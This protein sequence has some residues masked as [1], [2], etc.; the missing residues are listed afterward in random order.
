M[1]IP[2]WDLIK[3]QDHS[4]PTAQL[5]EE[6]YKKHGRPLRIA[7]DE[8]DWRFNN[9]TSQQVFIIRQ[10]SNQPAFQGVEKAMLY[11][12]C[13]MLTLNIQ[14]L[15]VFDG[16]RRPWKRGKR[17]GNKIDYESLRLLKELL[18]HFRIPHH[19]AP[20]EA[21]AECARLQ[22]LGI[23]D[24]VWSQDSDSLLFGCDLL[25]RDDRIARVK[26]N[27]DRSK[28]NTKKDGKSIKVVKGHEI[29]EKHRFDR[30]GLVLFAIIPSPLSCDLGL[31]KAPMAGGRQKLAKDSPPAS[32]A[33]YTFISGGSSEV[34]HIRAAR[35]QHFKD[36]Q[37]EGT[38]ASAPPASVSVTAQTPHRTKPMPDI[39][40]SPNTVIP[41]LQD[42]NAIECIDFT[43]L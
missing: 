43:D 9:L 6:H 15:F 4:V 20:G 5:A 37:K 25:I 11:R 32:P 13:H 18:A 16:P 12:I 1:G 40:I 29:V 2:I 39:V 3:E 38:C 42:T 7:V 14:L 30:E 10:K 8:A 35:L 17:G 19:E 22:V 26:G 33:Q 31:S 21:E 24:A 36:Q 28:E 34:A 41:R 23:V 27:T